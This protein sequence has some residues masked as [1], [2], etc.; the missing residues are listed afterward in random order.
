[1]R[2]RTISYR[3][4]KYNSYPL[5]KCTSYNTINSG[6]KFTATISENKVHCSQVSNGNKNRL[7]HDF[8]YQS[9]IEKFFHL[10]PDDC[11]TE[12][13][14][15]K[16]TSDKGTNRKLVNFQ[17]FPDSAQQAELERYQGHM[18]LDDKFPSQGAH[19]RITSD[20]Y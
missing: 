5:L 19:G 3:T 13:S 7:D 12:L 16:I 20:L 17:A 15:L 10:S 9:I 18:K 4:N 2:I 6:Y 8:F 11:K 1:M 14:Q